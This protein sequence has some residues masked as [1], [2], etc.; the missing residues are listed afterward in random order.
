MK[1]R[2]L[3]LVCFFCIPFGFARAERSWAKGE[4]PLKTRWF[5]SVTPD[6]ALPE[7]PRP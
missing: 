7:Y 2:F 1:F 5:D 3:I 4:P 6:N